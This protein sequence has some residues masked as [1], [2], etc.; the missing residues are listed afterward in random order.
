MRLDKFI[1]T[2]SEASRTL[3]KA[4]IKSGRARV[5]GVVVK[6]QGLKVKPEDEIF[7]NGQLISASGETYIALYKPEG[8]LSSTGEEEED[9]TV[10]DLVD[11]FTHKELHIAGR[12]DKDTTGLVLL[13]SDGK[14]SHRVTS[15]KFACEK[16]YRVKLADPIDEEIVEIFAE[17]LML[18]G[19]IKETLPAKLELLGER[20]GRLTITEGK[21]HQVRRMFGAVGNKVVELEREMIGC[22]TLRDL[23]PGEFYELDPEEVASFLK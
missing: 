7:V 3:A 13:T 5:N 17:G 8:V 4:A 2:H 6:D 23:E 15:P 10:I 16:V 22:V 9:D 1:A 11:G 21:Y 12:L 18:R 14:W 19:E 20:E